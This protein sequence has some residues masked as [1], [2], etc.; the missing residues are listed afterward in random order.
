MEKRLLLAFVLSA[1]L[2]GVW[3]VLF[4]PPRPTPPGDLEP[5][6]AGG[7][8]QPTAATA[9]P[10]TAGGEPAGEGEAGGPPA[11][12][13]EATT[14][15]RLQFANDELAVEVSNRGAAITSLVL[16]RF[17]G[18]QGEPLELVQTVAHPE[19][20]LPLQLVCADGVDERLYRAEPT[21]N[22]VRFI[23]SDG[24][25]S[26]VE[27]ELEVPASGYALQVSVATR[28]SR[29]GAP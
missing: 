10:D 27:K 28:G 19:R 23:W 22:G 9:A 26:V 13:V 17:T 7:T 15:E 4:P 14:E 21:E 18:D 11:E 5:T 1:V 24:R 29:R 6:A 8:V 12:A 20:A 25:G 3:A 2:F 16:R